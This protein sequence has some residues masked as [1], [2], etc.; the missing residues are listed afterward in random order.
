MAGAGGFQTSENL[1]ASLH[2]LNKDLSMVGLVSS[3][4][5]SQ[6]EFFM[7]RRRWNKQSDFMAVEWI[8]SFAAGLSTRLSF[9][10]EE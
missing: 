7:T 10:G 3:F 5:C 2:L 9:V 1:I 4:P 6:S 8:T